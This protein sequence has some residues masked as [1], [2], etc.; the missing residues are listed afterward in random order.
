MVIQLD[1]VQ[2][3]NWDDRWGNPGN[4]VASSSFS[5]GLKSES[6]GGKDLHFRNFYLNSANGKVY[7]SDIILAMKDKVTA[8]DDDV[9][10]VS[11]EAA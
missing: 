5:Y 11:F 3:S 10:I 1:G 6:I 9:S 4:G 8:S 7:E 2:N